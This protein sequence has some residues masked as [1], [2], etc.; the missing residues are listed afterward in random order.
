MDELPI[1]LLDCQEQCVQVAYK[2]VQLI[3]AQIQ[4]NMNRIVVH[5]QNM[6]AMLR[7]SVD[8]KDVKKVVEGLYEETGHLF[9]VYK[10]QQQN[11]FIGDYAA[12]GKI[13]C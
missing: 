12:L 5:S 1:I 9:L 3:A 7:T 8:H 2:Q 10:Q 6:K 4:D 11:L 13:F